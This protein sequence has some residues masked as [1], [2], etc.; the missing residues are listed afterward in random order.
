MHQYALSELD[1]FRRPQFVTQ[2]GLPHE[3]YLQKFLVGRLQIGQQ[4]DFLQ[5]FQAKILG[6]VNDQNGTLVGPILCDKKI[7][8][9]TQN[10]GFVSGRAHDAKI[11]VDH[12][13]KLGWTDLS[14]KNFGNCDACGNFFQQATDQGRFSSANFACQ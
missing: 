14:I 5:L 6:L 4:A 12:A 2:F 9:L 7:V 1:E 11:I 8:Q 10:S 3:N 13:Q